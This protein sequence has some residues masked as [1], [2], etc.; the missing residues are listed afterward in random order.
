MT[1]TLF[2]LKRYNKTL[3]LAYLIIESTYF[4]SCQF[5]SDHYL[6]PYINPYLFL[7]CD[8][9]PSQLNIYHDDH[10]DE[11]HGLLYP[12]VPL[13]HGMDRPEVQ[14]DFHDLTDALDLIPLSPLPITRPNLGDY[15]PSF[16]L[17]VTSMDGTF[18]LPS[19]AEDQSTMTAQTSQA[20]PSRLTKWRLAKKHRDYPFIY[21]LSVLSLQKEKKRA[22]KLVHKM[23][24]KAASSCCHNQTFSEEWA[25]TNFEVLFASLS[26]PF[27]LIMAMCKTLAWA[28]VE[29]GY[30]LRPSAWLTDSKTN[31]KARKINDLV[32]HSTWLP[33]CRANTVLVITSSLRSST[34]VSKFLGRDRWHCS[35]R[36]CWQLD[37]MWHKV[38]PQ[39]KQHLGDLVRMLQVNVHLKKS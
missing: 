12:P 21:Y 36:L 34:L 30:Q 29:H 5:R 15:H 35:K 24:V 2:E 13:Y 31:Q 19:T 11:G 7:P 23:L 22:I 37:P 18:M 20:G 9:D 14:Q 38:G 33:T 3:E 32:N 10:P 17:P 27:E 8:A 39:M 28:K 6:D 4:H 26:A 25:T 1:V 16:S